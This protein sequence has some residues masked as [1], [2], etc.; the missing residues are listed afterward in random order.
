MAASPLALAQ[1]THGAVAAREK[2]VAEFVPYTRHVD[3]ATLATK[4]G[5]LLQIIKLEGFPFETAADTT[6]DGLKEVRNTLTLALASSR[7]ILYH[8]LLRR[9][10]SK[11][12]AQG[13]GHF[14][15]KKVVVEDVPGGGPGQGEC[16][17]DLF[18]AAQGGIGGRRNP[19]PLHLDYTE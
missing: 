16:V 15:A 4:N 1:T 19:A 14:A 5:E 3:S 17:A 6:L 10:T 2:A 7:H 18:E 9:E 8:H 13:G 12:S 11:G